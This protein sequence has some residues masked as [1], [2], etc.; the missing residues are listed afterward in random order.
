MS[1]SLEN[2]E[3]EDEEIATELPEGAFGAE[4]DLWKLRNR[5][6]SLPKWLLKPWSF[7]ST[8]WFSVARY[9]GDGRGAGGVEAVPPRPRGAGMDDCEESDD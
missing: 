7:S 5:L 1:E 9:P 3:P 6:V 4:N 2:V 8:S